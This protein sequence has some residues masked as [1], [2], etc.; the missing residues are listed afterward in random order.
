MLSP[1]AITTSEITATTSAAIVRVFIVTIISQQP[2][3][4]FEGFLLNADGKR[5][6]RIGVCPHQ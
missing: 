1:E 3:Y 6:I 2:H 4:L 5:A